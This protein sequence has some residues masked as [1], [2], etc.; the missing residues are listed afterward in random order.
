LKVVNERHGVKK[1]KEKQIGSFIPSGEIIA[2]CSLLIIFI[3]TTSNFKIY[4]L[5]KCR[6]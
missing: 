5:G 6:L 3:Q 2:H 4:G 1:K